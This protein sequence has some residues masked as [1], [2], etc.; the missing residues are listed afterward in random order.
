MAGKSHET[1]GAM[2]NRA[3]AKPS[4]EPAKPNREPWI[5][6]TYAGFGDARQANRR[7]LHNLKQGQRGLSIAFDLPTQNGYDPDAPVA[8]GEVGKAGVSICHW[9][10]MEQLLDQI[11]LDQINTSMTIN[12]TAPF[13]LALYLVVAEKHGVPWTELRGT[14][15][16]DMLKEFVA[17]G[18]SIFDPELSLRLSTALIKF[19][20]ERVP[21]W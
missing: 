11:P 18:T 21:N 1:A 10:D 9:R 13:V 4:G 20:V 5:I 14:T 17:R 2:P 6:R 15:Q 16:N 3:P 12:A 19:A 7:F 8:A